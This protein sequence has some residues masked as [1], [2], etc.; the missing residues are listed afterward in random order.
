[1]RQN[2]S[3]DCARSQKRSTNCKRRFRSRS[4]LDWRIIFSVAATTRRWNSWKSCS[5]VTQTIL[6]TSHQKSP[7]AAGTSFLPP[8]SRERRPAEVTQAS[9][10]PQDGFA[11][12]NL[13]RRSGF[14]VRQPDG[15]VL[16]RACSFCDQARCR[17]SGVRAFARVLARTQLRQHIALPHIAGPFRA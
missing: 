2:T 9:S 4:I 12:V 10:P 3:I 17:F 7:K 1:M 16:W 5:G 11:V 8:I 14:P 13:T 15:L 6:S